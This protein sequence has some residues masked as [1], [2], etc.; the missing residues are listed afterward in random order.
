MRCLP[1]FAQ[2]ADLDDEGLV[3]DL[4]EGDD[5]PDDPRSLPEKP[6]FCCGHFQV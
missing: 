4:L 3:A 2:H 1:S 6:E 5:R